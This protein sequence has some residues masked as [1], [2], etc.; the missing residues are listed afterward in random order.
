MRTELFVPQRENQLC[1]CAGL[2]GRQSEGGAVTSEARGW[3]SD[4]CSDPLADLVALGQ[5]LPLGALCPGCHRVFLPP[6]VLGDQMAQS[7]SQSV[8]N[9]SSPCAPFCPFFSESTTLVDVDIALEAGKSYEINMNVVS[10]SRMD[11][12]GVYLLLQVMMLIQNHPV[13][14]IAMVNGLATAAG[15]Q[16]VASCDIAVAS[17]KSSFAAPGVN[18]GLFCSTPGV[19]LGRAVPRKVT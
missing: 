15:C 19:A 9:A 3:E 13:P 18:I 6:G 1:S 7:G 8:F 11:V 2:P 5:L 16:L 12:N 17:D 14:V 10:H 4:R